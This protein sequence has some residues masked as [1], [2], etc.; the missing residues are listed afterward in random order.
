MEQTDVVKESVTG[1]KQAPATVINPVEYD[2]FGK[3][4]K[5]GS[6]KVSVKLVNKFSI[7]PKDPG[8]K[9][10]RDEVTKKIGASWKKG[11]RDVIRGLSP[12]EEIFYLPGIL[13]VRKESDQW[14]Q[15][16]LD[17]WCNFFIEVPTE[18]GVILEVGFQKN[19]RTG[20]VEPIN[21]D[22]YMKY[23]WCKEHGAVA[24]SP[25][26]LD[27]MFIYE[28][29]VVDTQKE[30]EKE[31]LMF[32][33][34]KKIDRIFIKLVESKDTKDLVKIDWIL[35]TAGGDNG[36]GI[37]IAGLS[38]TQKQMELEKMKDKDLFRFQDI[39]TDP[40]L[41]TKALIRKA[42]SAGVLI[43]DGNSYFLDSKVLGSNLQQTVGYLENSANQQD[44]L[45]VIERIKNHIA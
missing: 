10:I 17:F 35:E 21:L 28:F 15:K 30:Q 23:N 19:V 1:A 11:T 31:E 44:K 12:E 8:A 24:T 3:K 27:N 43:Q 22:D 18:G 13:G 42:V 34:R 5:L 25:E 32:E 36:L 40:S 38:P 14:N 6:R 41:E 7:L 4:V 2:H 20:A 9:F 26:Q 37:N 45:L 39:V 33:M 16:V 29:Y